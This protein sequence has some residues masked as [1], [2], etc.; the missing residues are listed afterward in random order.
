MILILLKRRFFGHLSLY[1]PV[2]LGVTTIVEAH[3]QALDDIWHPPCFFFQFATSK[4]YPIT[5]DRGGI[6]KTKT[7]P[8]CVCYRGQSCGSIL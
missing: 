1:K 2:V 8:K 7:H 5:F 3:G 6:R 4:E